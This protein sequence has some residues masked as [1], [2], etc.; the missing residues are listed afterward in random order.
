MKT[1]SQDDFNELL[2]R[3][4]IKPRLKRE[5]R[6]VSSTSKL[7]ADWS[8]YEL[9]SITDRTG[10]RGV[11]LIQPNDKLYIAPYEL[12]RRIVDSKT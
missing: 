7:D 11:L 8:G 3:T 9:I 6:F 12:S 10:D 5:L 1:L 2:E 4:D